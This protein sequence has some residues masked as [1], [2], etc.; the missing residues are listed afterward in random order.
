MEHLCN[1]STEGRDVDLWE[2]QAAR[3]TLRPRFKLPKIVI[4]IIITKKIT[5]N[6]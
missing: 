1:P 5:Q 3:S 6:C 4:V 2:F